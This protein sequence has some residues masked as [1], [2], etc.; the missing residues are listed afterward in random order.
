M[1][2]TN[3]L[4]VKVKQE[5]IKWLYLHTEHTQSILNMAN[6]EQGVMLPDY[7]TSS[8][9]PPHNMTFTTIGQMGAIVTQ[10]CIGK[11]KKQ[12][13]HLAALKIVCQL[14]GVDDISKPDTSDGS[15]AS[16][17]GKT[18]S[19]DNWKGRVLEI[20]QKN[21]WGFPN[22]L[23]SASG[24]L[25]ECDVSL[26]VGGVQYKLTGG[27]ASTKKDAE[28][29]AARALIEKLPTRP[30]TAIPP[31]ADCSN[32]IG[33][34]G[35]FCTAH[36]Y[37]PPVYS[38]TKSGQDNACSFAVT[39]SVKINGITFTKSGRGSTK[40]LAKHLAAQKLYAE[41]LQKAQDAGA[42]GVHY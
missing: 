6:Q 7:R 4:W 1:A 27:R 20:C 31:A 18:I 14:A 11:T 15:P 37:P 39:C 29:L 28:Q 21:N 12:A 40:K 8:T 17:A 24:F 10:P 22:F 5:I 3:V 2:P 42:F 41:M 32:Y 16:L 33:L 13:E 9:G 36:H 30:I 35:E 19:A 26:S 38:D 23:V 34:L 25:F